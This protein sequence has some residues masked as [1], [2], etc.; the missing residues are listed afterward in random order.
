MESS[1][2]A[3]RLGKLW[4]ELGIVEAKEE[5]A[6]DDERHHSMLHFLGHIKMYRRNQATERTILEAM[7]SYRE[8][9]KT[10]HAIPQPVL[11]KLVLPNLDISDLPPQY[12][13]KIV[14]AEDEFR[15]RSD[16]EIDDAM[17][18]YGRET[19]E[20]K[21]QLRQQC[22]KERRS[23]ETEISRLMQ[24]LEESADEERKRLEV[25][26]AQGKK[27]TCTTAS[28]WANETK[29][30]DEQTT[31]QVVPRVH[32]VPRTSV[33]IQAA[34]PPDDSGCST[35]SNFTPQKQVPDE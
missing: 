13:E 28:E 33:K 11:E 5:A 7:K 14:A 4:K 23:I 35:A 19:R 34:V 15:G 12:L 31:E 32:P 6:R 21:Q 29:T 24:Q 20:K 27:F 26:S 10:I 9:T 16:K 8:A 18:V 25:L 2:L 30:V 17:V 1:E 22:E 3:R